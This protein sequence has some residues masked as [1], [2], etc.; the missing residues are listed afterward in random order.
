MGVS[1]QICQAGFLVWPSY[2]PGL[3]FPS[4]RRNTYTHFCWLFNPKDK[5]D[6][7]GSLAVPK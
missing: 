7:S 3:H 1:Q 6:F 2:R 4:Y 5:L